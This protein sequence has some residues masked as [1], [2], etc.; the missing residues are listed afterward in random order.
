LFVFSVPFMFLKKQAAIFAGA[1]FTGLAGLAL[2]S[3]NFL[4]AW[5]QEIGAGT[6]TAARMYLGAVQVT[7]AACAVVIALAALM[8]R[9]L[10]QVFSQGS[11]DK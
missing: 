8:A 9:G 7:T 3:S 2:F 1:A 5:V 11:A 4:G 6:T 10:V